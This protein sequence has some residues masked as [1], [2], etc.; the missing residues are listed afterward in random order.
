MQ[1]LRITLIQT[2]LI[3]EDI[4]ANLDLFDKKIDSISQDTDLI[5]LPEMFTTGFSMNAE[6]LAQEM[7]GTS[8]K[9]LLDKSRQKDVDIV[10]SIIVTEKQKYFN[11]LIW[12]TPAGN[13]LSYDK[14]HLFRML[15]EHKVYSAGNRRITVGLHGW[16]IRPFICYDLRFPAWVRNSGNQ[17]DLAIFIA[18]WPERRA[19]HWKVLLQARAIENQ[20]YVVGVN[21]VGTDGNDL[22]HSGDSCL[23]DPAGEV[24]HQKSHEPFIYTTVLSYQ[25]LEEYRKAFP[26]WMDADQITIR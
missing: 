6:P 8:V 5:V 10:G 23:I 7:E 12:A 17:Y 4:Q 9:W 3:W 18:N 22:Y 24:L 26:A 21:R 19:L 13:L 2:E 1:D 15:G 11:R 14:R 16:K 20:C 25:L